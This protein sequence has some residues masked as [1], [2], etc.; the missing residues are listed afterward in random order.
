MGRTMKELCRVM[1]IQ[2]MQTTAYHP[3]TN[4]AVERVW[5]NLTRH[6]RR[7]CRDR[8]ASWDLHLASVEMALRT[9]V[10]R[11]I[12]VSPFELM[13]GR[14]PRLPMEALSGG[15]RRPQ[16]PDAAV[17]FVEELKDNL[18]KQYQQACQ[19]NSVNRERDLQ[20]LTQSRGRLED[21]EVG[22]V[23]M[24]FTPQTPAGAKE[25]LVSMWRGP[26]KITAKKGPVTY[27]VEHQLLSGL[28][29]QVVHR[30]RLKRYHPRRDAAAHQSEMQLART[31]ERVR[32]QQPG[33]ALGVP[34]QK[35]VGR[36]KIKGRLHYKV[37]WLGHGPRADTWE[38]VEWLAALREEI[39][40]FEDAQT[41]KSGPRQRCRRARARRT[42]GGMWKDLRLSAKV[43]PTSRVLCSVD[44]SQR[45]DRLHVPMQTARCGNR[46]VRP[47]QN[48][49]SCG[50]RKLA[51]YA[52]S[53]WSG[54]R[55]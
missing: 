15:A 14:N 13:Y 25:K 33:H 10:V 16:G 4:S 18:R 45:S 21:L 54:D 32:Q 38:P 39:Q 41:A 3:Q 50:T 7:F 12:G 36:K 17:L 19:L 20:S 44:Q 43:G 53:G 47:R 49:C 23:V 29:T 46:Q 11:S 30:N 35:I 27:Q 48:T 5:P 42:T 26:Y 22:D 8:Q 2:K 55:L 52:A 51:E 40:E 37:R 1:G 6:L 9:S 31:Q 28:P 24:V 34:A